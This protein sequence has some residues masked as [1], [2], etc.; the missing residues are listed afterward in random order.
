[1]IDWYFGHTDSD[2]ALALIAAATFLLL[3]L[4]AGF[5]LLTI[6]L[7][8]RSLRRSSVRSALEKSWTPLVIGLLAG[9]TDAAA[10]RAAVAR[11]RQLFFVDY[12]LR[13]VSRFTGEDR[14][15]IRELARPYLGDVAA[16]LRSRRPEARA[17]AVQTL[18]L[19]GRDEYDRE[20]VAALDDESLTVAMVA[21]RALA[22]REHVRFAPEILRR[23]H[24]FRHWN[25]RYLATLFAGM[26]PEVLPSLR[27]VYASPLADPYVRRVA[28]DALYELDDIGAAPTA[29][30]I[31]RESADPELVA[32]S[33]HLLGRVGGPEHADVARRALADANPVLRLRGV[34]ALAEIGGSEDL[35]RLRSALDDPSPWVALAAARGLAR[36]GGS[37]LLRALT[38]ERTARGTLAREVLKAY[39]RA[40]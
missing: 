14:R 6:G 29:H 18:M 27:V 13:Y 19:L 34:E 5:A 24:R 10:V 35:L 40:A 20:V 38:E 12:L 2:R 22:A 33:I 37:D 11:P 7:R 28:A 31:A 1:M 3:V 26:G 15:A 9:D 23:V 8:L 32:A 16:Q 17:R 25:A 30:A 21:A 39:G 4:A 36:G